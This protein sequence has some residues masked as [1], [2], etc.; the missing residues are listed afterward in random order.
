M[1]RKGRA[2]LQSRTEAPIAI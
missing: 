2:V 1:G